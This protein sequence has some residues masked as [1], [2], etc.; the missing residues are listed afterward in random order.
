MYVTIPQCQWKWCVEMGL[1]IIECSILLIKKSK[2][3]FDSKKKFDYFMP[4][5]PNFMYF[6]SK[7]MSKTQGFMN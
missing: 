6:T 7:F 2:F 4:I 5:K 3:F 1:T